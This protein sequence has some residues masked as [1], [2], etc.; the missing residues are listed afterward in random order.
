MIDA[1]RRGGG[2]GKP[3]FLKAGLSY[4]KTGAE[5]LV[6]AHE[7]WRSVS[8]PNSVLTELRTPEEFDAVGK[9][10]RLED[11]KPNLRI[12]GDIAQHAAWIAADMELGFEEI[13]LHN[14]GRNQAEYIDAFGAKLL[15][16][17]R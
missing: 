17:F 14:V 8:F 2:D 3:L 12:S 7:Q 6:N 10:I 16:Q 4:A 1:F 5:A 15:P 11:L 13:F 9:Y